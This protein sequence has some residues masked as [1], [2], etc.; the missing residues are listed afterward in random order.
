VPHSP[1]TYPEPVLEEFDAVLHRARDGDGDAFRL[2]FDDLAGP[3]AG[4]LRGRGASDVEDLTSD[5]FLAA[6]TGLDR[7]TGGQQEFRSWLFTIAHRRVVD[8]WRRSA[9]T[10]RLVGL[11][12]V[13]DARTIPSAE[14]QALDRIG[15]EQVN[16]L[17]SGL[18]PDQRDVLLLRIVA[19]LTI[20]QVAEVMGKRPGAVK[21][22]QRRGLAALRSMLLAQGVPL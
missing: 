22:L 1:L 12:G 4:Y 8:Q 21:A 3:V 7:F 15:Q 5:V 16:A 10:P 14:R 6:F 2:L 19:D 20:E 18:S 11:D 9:R 17:L 13:D